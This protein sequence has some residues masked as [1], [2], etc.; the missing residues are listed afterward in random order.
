M[1]TLGT[2]SNNETKTKNKTSNLQNIKHLNNKLNLLYLLIICSFIVQIITVVFFYNLITTKIL[3]ES[4]PTPIKNNHRH[5]IKRQVGKEKTDIY[6]NALP[7]E[8]HVEFI[9]PTLKQEMQ[10]KEKDHPNST[11]N[12]PWVW[13]T[14]YSRVP[15]TAMQTFC[16]ATKSYCPPGLQGPPGQ[17]GEVGEK[18]DI[19]LKG[20]RGEKGSLGERGPIGP[21]GIL[22]EEGKR[23][24][25]GDMGF[26]GRQGMDGR[27]GLPGEPGLDGIPGRNGMDGIPGKD[28]LSGK[29]GTPGTNGTNGAMGQ[30]GPQG[31]PGPQG[32]P[33]KP[34]ITGPRGRPGKFGKD[35]IPGTPAICAYKQE[36]CSLLPNSETSQLLIPPSIVGNHQIFSSTPIVV[37]EGDNVRLRC[38]A[39][40]HPKPAIIW[41]TKENVPI[42]LGSWR[43]SAVASSTLNF[44]RI[45]RKNMGAYMCLADNGIAP[46]ANQTFN[47]EVHF[48]PLISVHYTRVGVAIGGTARLECEVE[49]FP[50]SVK[51]WEFI[52]GTLI[53]PDNDKYFTNDIDRGPYKYTMQLNISHVNTSD[54][55]D[56]RCISK[57]EVGITKGTVKL[58]PFSE[59]NPNLVAPPQ[60][61]TIYNPP[62]IPQGQED[63]CPPQV[64]CPPCSEQNKEFKC[65]EGWN[66]YELVGHREFEVLPLG[67]V[68]IKNLPNR[69]LDCQVYAVGKPVFHKSTTKK[70][71]TGHGTVEVPY[72]A[73]MRDPCNGSAENN[74]KF[75]M[76]VEHDPTHLYEY[77]DK[78]TFKSDNKSKTYNL[79][80]QFQG[81]AHVVYNNSFYYNKKFSDTIIQFDLG[82]SKTINSVSFPTVQPGIKLYKTGFNVMDFSLDENGLWVI[83]G[84]SN[85]NTAIMKLDTATLQIQYQWNISVVHNKAGDMFVVCGVLYVVDSVTERITTIR[86]ALDLYKSKLLDV[87][88]NFTNPFKNTT[89]VTYN[90]KYTD[91]VT[92]DKGNS[93]TYPIRYHYIDLDVNKQDKLEAD[94]STGIDVTPTQPPPTPQDYSSN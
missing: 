69:T 84:L 28:G 66:W 88:L 36:T 12:N 52:D 49:S 3:E 37:R 80:E 89:M 70:S 14:S 47:L 71:D 13:L 9:P 8:P 35:G 15:M 4:K 43:D 86:F 45:H 55:G 94:L 42:I 56:Y 79:K 5:R 24:P 16:K 77:L 75:W 65:K 23:G 26:P 91:L 87:N 31:A 21:Q 25:K 60:D 81:N 46:M 39:T 10:E 19:G 34:G 85:N 20:D 72:G 82:S 64:I 30:T 53:E 73:W 93:L 76:T 44:T 2:H 67:N 33:G 83:Y 41:R 48:S 61:R 17:K 63:L 68:S 54:Y 11:H 1:V 58:V 50:L 90:S 38:V 62:P 92:W 59:N 74:N 57:N 51:Y 40:G 78:D 32:V 6:D 29:D 27:D 7:Q 18:G 22:G